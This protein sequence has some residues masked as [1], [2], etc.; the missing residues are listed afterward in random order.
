MFVV[1]RLETWDCFRAEH[2]VFP[3]IRV[4]G[5]EGS[6]GF[7]LVFDTI[8]DAH[9]EY[10]EDVAVSEIKLKGVPMAKTVEIEEKTLRVLIECFCWHCSSE[11]GM[12]CFIDQGDGYCNAIGHA[13]CE[14][15]MLAAVGL[16]P[17]EEK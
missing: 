17:E 5:L 14:R 13:E 7:L 9:R 8:E 6:P 12:P 11:R 1:M 3:T 10:G 16:E 4:K 15:R 2:P